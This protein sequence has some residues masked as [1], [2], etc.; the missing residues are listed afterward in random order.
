MMV[1]KFYPFS[2]ATKNVPLYGGKPGTFCQNITAKNMQ[3][4]VN[5]T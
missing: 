5:I 4:F 3:I 2:T 1:L